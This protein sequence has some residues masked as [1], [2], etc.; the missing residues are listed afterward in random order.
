MAIYLGLDNGMTVGAEYHMNI[1]DSWIGGIGRYWD[2]FILHLGHSGPAV[3]YL[4]GRR[5]NS[6]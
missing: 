4:D 2:Q 6:I 3:L 1:A 5:S